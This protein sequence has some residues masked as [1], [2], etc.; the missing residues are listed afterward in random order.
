MN[1]KPTVGGI[2]DIPKQVVGKFLEELGAAGVPGD[3]VAR[4]KKTLLDD[5]ALT[6]PAVRRAIFPDETP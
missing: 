6:E 3:V 5:G 4:L 1:G 2:S